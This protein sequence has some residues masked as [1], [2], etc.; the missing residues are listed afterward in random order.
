M[1]NTGTIPLHSLIRTTPFRVL[2]EC[3]PSKLVSYDRG[4]AGMFDLDEYLRRRDEVLDELKGHLLR[5]QQ[6]MITQADKKQREVEFNVRE[7]VYLKI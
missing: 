1:P 5:S 3:E 4:L 7:R 6:L 2:Y